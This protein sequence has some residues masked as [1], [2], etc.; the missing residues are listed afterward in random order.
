MENGYYEG[1]FR[2]FIKFG[3]IFFISYMINLIFFED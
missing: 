1:E 2:L 3:E